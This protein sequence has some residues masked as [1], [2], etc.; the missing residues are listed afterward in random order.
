MLWCLKL[1]IIPMEDIPINNNFFF[2]HPNSLISLFNQ[3]IKFKLNSKSIWKLLSLRV[4]VRIDS[5]KPFNILS[6]MN[7]ARVLIW[8]PAL[9]AFPKVKDNWKNLYQETKPALIIDFLLIF[10]SRNGLRKNLGQ[11]RCNILVN[12][13]KKS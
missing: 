10:Y 11:A 13:F 1:N 4:S 2:T 6:Y 9:Q 7:M 5:I 8:L 3:S 12:Y